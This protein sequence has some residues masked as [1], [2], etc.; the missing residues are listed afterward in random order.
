MSLLLVLVILLVLF[1][2]GGFQGYRSGQLGGRGLSLGSLVF[3]V[4]VVWLVMRH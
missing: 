1:G 2:G 3:V 4:L